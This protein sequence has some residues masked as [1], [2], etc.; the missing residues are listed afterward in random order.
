M[1]KPVLVGAVLVLAAAIGGGYWWYQNRAADAASEP[2]GAPQGGF[3][4]PVE[5]APV[6]VGRVELSIPA[7]GSLR[8]NESVVI[9]PE[10]AGRL[11]A[12]L[13]EEG[14]R[15]TEGTLVA[16]L[17]QS[18]YQAELAQATASLELSKADVERARSMQQ[19]DVASLQTVQQAE[20]R[21]RANTAAIALAQ[22]QLA[23]TEIYAPF[24]GILGL[25]RVSVGDY[26]EAGDEIINLEQVDPLK[27]DFRIP[28]TYFSIAKV[29]QTI[30]ILVDALPGETF[31]GRIYAID[32]LIDREGRSILIRAEV[33]NASDRLRPGL[34]VSIDLVYDARENAVLVPEQAIVPIG[35][36]SYVFRVVEGKAAQTEVELGIRQ[37]GRVEVTKGLAAGDTVVTAGQL[38]IADGVPVAP[39]PPQGD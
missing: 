7:I 19:K 16:K 33:P 24:D 15:V 35:R 38:K 2:A 37:G 29:G 12:I 21:L 14:Q 5:A 23:K 30:Q 9:A 26:L 17:D 11:D 22:A 32:P 20:S 18:V 27:V 4:V 36:K 28:E 6:E 8:S 1:R 34:F 39:Q 10:I 31:E 25:R 13:V 3:A